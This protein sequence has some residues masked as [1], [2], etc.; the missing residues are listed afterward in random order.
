MPEISIFLRIQENAKKKGQ[1]NLIS[2]RTYLT[3]RLGETEKGKL[4]PSKK[5]LDNRRHLREVKKEKEK[6]KERKKERKRWEQEKL[7]KSSG[8]GHSKWVL[9]RHKDLKMKNID[10][11]RKY[12]KMLNIHVSEWDINIGTKKQVR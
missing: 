6:K 4:F 11:K 10:K 5:S 8:T 9:K 1:S 12:R 2:C 7:D 3:L